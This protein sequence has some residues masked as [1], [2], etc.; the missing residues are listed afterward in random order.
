MLDTAKY[1]AALM[2]RLSTLDARLHAI[3]AELDAP[4]SSDW[5]ELAIERE[6]D[7]VL[8]SL[9]QSGEM[10]IARIRAALA[11]LRNG[12]YGICTVCGEEISSER[13]DV[14][15]ETPMCRVCAASAS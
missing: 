4:R 14:L 7:E 3:E 6:G 8:E 5:E 1:H 10:E 15:P 12:T 11:R 9:G 2:Q 13:L